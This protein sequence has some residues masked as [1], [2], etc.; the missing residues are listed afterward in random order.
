MSSAHVFPKP[1][2]MRIERPDQRVLSLAISGEMDRA[3]NNAVLDAFQA[4]V[5]DPDLPTVILDLTELD[6]IDS[7]G[8]NT[9]FNT[10]RAPRDRDGTQLIVWVQGLSAG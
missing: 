5:D 8:L 6:F 1:F 2:S 3:R 7:W 10:A 4:A 9:A